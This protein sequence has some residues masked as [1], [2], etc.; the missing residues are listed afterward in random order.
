MT[1]T[2]N[3]KVLF[4][5]S[6]EVWIQKNRLI[7]NDQAILMICNCPEIYLLNISISHFR[8]ASAGWFWFSF[9]E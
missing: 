1:N 8:Y 4:H 2:S 3:K 9:V 6:L 5:L 7:I